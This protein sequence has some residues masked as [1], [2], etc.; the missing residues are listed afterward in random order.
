[1]KH[2]HFVRFGTL[3]EV[4]QY[5]VHDRWALDAG[6]HL[7]GAVVLTGFDDDL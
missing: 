4:I 3:F 7:D 1:M 5:P 2:A 6:D